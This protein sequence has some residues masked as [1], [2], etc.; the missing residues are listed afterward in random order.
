MTRT[1]LRLI[2][3]VALG[4]AIAAVVPAVAQARPVDLSGT[5]LRSLH[6]QAL[7]VSQDKLVP[8]EAADLRSLHAE[9]LAASQYKLGPGEIPS[10]DE[11]FQWPSSEQGMPPTVAKNTGG[12]DVDF[13]VVAGGALILL[14]FIAG[15]VVAVRH[16]RETRMAPA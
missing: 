13:G 9:A 12:Y 14:L 6:A 16:V 10:I 5:D 11:G 15:S 4:L 3:R 1:K 8:A 7:A 2:R